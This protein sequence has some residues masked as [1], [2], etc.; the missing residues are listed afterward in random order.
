MTDAVAAVRAWGNAQAALVGAGNPIALGFFDARRLRSPGRGCYA[1]VEADQDGFS[2]DAEG[3]TQLWRLSIGVRSA[4][5]KEA[6]ERGALALADSLRAISATQPLAAGVRLLMAVS[7]VV[8]DD[9]STDDEPLFT[10]Q[11]DLY[12]A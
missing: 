8:N 4:T 1:F 3:L 2:L 10:V 6:A 7:V 11:A 12:T 5:D 9:S